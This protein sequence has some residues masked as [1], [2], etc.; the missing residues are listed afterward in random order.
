MLR[1]A[2]YGIMAA[3]ALSAI[4]ALLITGPAR[5]SASALLG[6]S[7]AAGALALYALAGRLPDPRR[8][9]FHQGLLCMFLLCI[10]LSA[11]MSGAWRHAWVGF[12]FDMLSAGFLALSC[13]VALA[14]PVASA[15]HK[16]GML[17][18]AGAAIVL[19]WIAPLVRPAP[20]VRPG[21]GA[22]I[23]IALAA[24]SESART[25]LLGSGPN[26]FVYAWAEHAPE[27]VLQTPFWA[28]RFPVGSGVLPTLMVEAGLIAALILT[29]ACIARSLEHW[30]AAWGSW[31]ALSRRMRLLVALH[32]AAPVLAFAALMLAPPSAA[33]VLCA[34]VLIGASG[35]PPGILPERSMP[36]KVAL[37]LP[38]LIVVGL[39]LYLAVAAFFYFR[40]NAAYVAGDPGGARMAALRSVELAGDPQALRLFAA[41][42]RFDAHVKARAE[43]TEAAIALYADAYGRARSA[44]LR[45][46]AHPDNWILMGVIAAEQYAATR[47]GEYFELA[48]SAFVNARPRAPRDARIP[49]FEGQ[50]Y[51]LAGRKEEGIAFLRKSLL[52]RPDLADAQALLD[53]VLASPE[54]EER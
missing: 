46:P 7:L 16:T 42:L 37:T 20:E 41:A 5:D 6:A 31:Q 11:S 33:L 21:L 29:L 35:P 54:R 4:A 44:N 24:T 10:V 30:Y 14:V 18:V 27:S 48:R 34:F 45:E 2:S 40:A 8:F 52:M 36:A 15:R 53:S 9:G 3:C 17:A 28:E 25:L 39:T 26:S 32:I 23:G 38:F 43:D 22:T 51:L 47:D 12:S 19:L 50:L 49:L 1:W 13:L